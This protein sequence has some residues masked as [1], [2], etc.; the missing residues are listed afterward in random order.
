MIYRREE[1]FEEQPN[2]AK[3]PIRQIEQLTSLDGSVK[4]FV[5]RVTLGVQTPMG[6]TSLP[7][8]FEIEAASLQE[9]FAKFPQ[10]AETEVEAAKGELQEEL[11]EM[12]RKSQSRIVTPGELPPTGMGKLRL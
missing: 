2:D 3:F 8:S 6:V 7:V 11:M 5:G 4:K 1:F 10:R 12:R 9:A